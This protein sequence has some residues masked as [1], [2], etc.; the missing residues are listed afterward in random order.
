ML[1]LVPFLKLCLLGIG[2]AKYERRSCLAL[3]YSGSKDKKV[4]K[5]K[6]DG[7]APVPRIRV[8]L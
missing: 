8:F 4:G 3:V 5:S 7:Q 6:K 1:K 2:S